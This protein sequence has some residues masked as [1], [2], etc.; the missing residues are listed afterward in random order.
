MVFFWGLKRTFWRSWILDANSSWLG[1]FPKMTYI[2]LFNGWA[3]KASDHPSSYCMSFSLLKVPWFLCQ[4]LILRPSIIPF[5]SLYLLRSLILTRH[6]TIFSF[7][8]IFQGYIWLVPRL[9]FASSISFSTFLGFLPK[10][11]LPG[12]WVI[13]PWPKLNSPP[14]YFFLSPSFFL[15]L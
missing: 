13:R 12:G 7:F 4:V 11:P 14:F 6:P 1:L 9:P 3:W 8:S 5:N 2:S 15:G 10:D